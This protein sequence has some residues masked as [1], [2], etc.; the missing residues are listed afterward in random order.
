MF[1]IFLLRSLWDKSSLSLWG[2]GERAAHPHTHREPYRK[3]SYQDLYIRNGGN[4]LKRQCGFRSRIYQS[5]TPTYRSITAPLAKV[6][7]LRGSE[8]YRSITA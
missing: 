6:P 4:P 7:F 2:L 8:S 5:I 3:A 1:F